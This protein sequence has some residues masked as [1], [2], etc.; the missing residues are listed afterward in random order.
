MIGD[1]TL[2]Q[3]HMYKQVF[4]AF[5]TLLHTQIITT[6]CTEYGRH[7]IMHTASS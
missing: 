7:P 4:G 6:G 5:L 1:C 3:H 2:L